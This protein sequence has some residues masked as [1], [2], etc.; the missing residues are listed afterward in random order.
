MPVADWA[1]LNDTH[2]LL[3]DVRE[4]NEFARGH[5]PNAINLPLSQLRHRYSELP[6]HGDIWLC[7]AVGQRAYYAARFLTQKGYRASNLSGGYTTY[8]MLK[9]AGL[10]K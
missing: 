3:L 7:C 10:L 8:K 1:E 9:S 4:P 2:A 6:K 5:I